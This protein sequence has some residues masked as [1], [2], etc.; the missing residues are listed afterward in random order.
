M[1]EN[2]EIPKSMSLKSILFLT[3]LFVYPNFATAAQEHCSTRLR[4]NSLSPTKFLSSQEER[5]ENHKCGFGDG[6]DEIAF[7]E[8]IVIS[9]AGFHLINVALFRNELVS[10]QVN[11]ESL[12]AISCLEVLK[13]LVNYVWIENSGQLA[14]SAIALVAL[15]A[16]RMSIESQT[17]HSSKYF[18]LEMSLGELLKNRINF[19]VTENWFPRKWSTPP[20]SPSFL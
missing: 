2:S 10:S 6:S 11:K 19:V 17:Q 18:L 8:S 20:D 9:A 5:A 13:N 14:L 1:S 16:F 7:M 4:A 3:F 15:N 12:V